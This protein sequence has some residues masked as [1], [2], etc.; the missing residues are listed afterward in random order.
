MRR[1]ELKEIRRSVSKYLWMQEE[2]G[3][4]KQLTI[5]INKKEQEEQWVELMNDKITELEKMIIK[6]NG[7][8]TEKSIVK[9][10]MEEAIKEMKMKLIEKTE[11]EMVYI[12]FK[13]KLEF[14][15]K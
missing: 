1:F 2:L 12:K 8:D 13:E 6:Y 11:E 3:E 14:I 5:F 10:L 9:P 15:K 4:I 7:L